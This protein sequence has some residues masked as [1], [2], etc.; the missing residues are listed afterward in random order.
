MAGLQGRLY[1]EIEVKGRR[2][3]RNATPE[4]LSERISPDRTITV[5]AGDHFIR[6][7]H[8][9]DK[10]D[11]QPAKRNEKE[12][13][14][15]TSSRGISFLIKSV[16]SLAACRYNLS[17]PVREAHPFNF[18]QPLR[19]LVKKEHIHVFRPLGHAEEMSH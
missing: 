10:V 11:L 8:F 14:P 13:I 16:V 3:G 18:T 1:G 2:R 5:D 9:R 4:P 19:F 7:S 6:A 15:R 12:R 17:A